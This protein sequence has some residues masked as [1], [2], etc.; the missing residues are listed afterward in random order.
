MLHLSSVP[1]GVLAVSKQRMGRFTLLSEAA[2]SNFRWPLALTLG[3][4]LGPAP[5]G[6]PTVFL[7]MMRVVS[8]RFYHYP[9]ITN[10]S[11]LNANNVRSLWSDFTVIGLS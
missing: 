9:G 5:E 1:E 11:P 6:P 7:L 4:I 3:T 2:E 10:P 8:R